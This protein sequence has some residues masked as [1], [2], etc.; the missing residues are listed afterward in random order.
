MCVGGVL[1]DNVH[2][3]KDLIRKYFSMEKF[4]P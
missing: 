1:H 4:G 2:T 3:D